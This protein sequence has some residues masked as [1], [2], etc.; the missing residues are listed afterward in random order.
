MDEGRKRFAFALPLLQCA[1][2]RRLDRVTETPAADETQSSAPG[3]NSRLLS[4]ERMSDDAA[5]AS[6]SPLVLPD[7]PAGEQLIHE[8]KDGGVGGVDEVPAFDPFDPG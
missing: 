7:L 6:W 5:T 1:K 2:R 4:A 3:P 8:A